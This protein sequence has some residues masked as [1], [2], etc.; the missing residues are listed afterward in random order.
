MVPQPAQPPGSRHFRFFRSLSA[1]MLR[2]MATT[3]GRSPGGYLWMILEPAAGIALLSFVFSMIARSPAIGSNF[4]LFFATGLMV[5]QLYS[6]ISNL[7]AKALT[8]S[9]PFL[10]YPAV[11]F[12]DALAARIFLNTLTQILVMTIVIYAI[13]LIYDL[14]LILDWGAIGNAL[15]MC[16]SFGAAVGTMNCYL[17]ERIPLWERFWTVLNR[18]MFILSGILFIPEVVPAR[19][20]DYYMM[21]PLPHMTS[22]MRRGFYATY[23]GAYVQPVYVYVISVVVLMLGMILLLRNHKYLAE[24]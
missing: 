21:L 23:E 7:T 5:F 24:L 6:T 2:E 15:A 12:V 18:P 4:P 14:K 1:L 3:Y 17:F 10:A 19:L 20:R 22:E 9:K 16:I 8:F 13:I 11:T